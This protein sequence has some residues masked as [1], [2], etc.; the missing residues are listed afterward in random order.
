MDL[1]LQD[2][3]LIN[4]K[5]KSMR[6][7]FLILWDPSLIVFW[8]IRKLENPQD[9]AVTIQRWQTWNRMDKRNSV[10]I[11]ERVYMMKNRPNSFHH[12]FNISKTQHSFKNQCPNSLLEVKDRDL[13][14]RRLLWMFPVQVHT[15]VRQ[16]WDQNLLVKPWE[17]KFVLLS[18]RLELI[19]FLDLVRIMEIIRRQGPLSQDG[20]L[21]LEPDTIEKILWEGHA[22]S[23]QW[24][25]IIQI[26]ERPREAFQNGDSAQVWEEDLSMEKLFL[27]L[28]RLT[29]FQVRLLK[30]AAGVWAWNYRILVLSALTV[31]SKSNC[32]DQEL[33]NQILRQH[34]TK[35]HSSRWKVDIRTKKNLMFPDQEPMINLWSIRKQLLNSVLDLVLNEKPL[36]RLW[37]QDQVDIIS[38]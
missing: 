23:H 2:L 22:I 19:T 29:T 5:I 21:V 37:A 34:K 13:K 31:I 18:K 16:L 36:R 24:T 33:I 35:N 4:Q 6:N 3:V 1:Y 8:L 26:I 38:Q 11:T 32:Q 28:C 20:E 15:Q 17:W 25:R 12:H 14:L 30:R 7:L 10:K 9:Q 27:H